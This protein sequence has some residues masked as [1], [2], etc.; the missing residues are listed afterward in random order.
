MLLG[1]SRRMSAMTEKNNQKPWGPLSVLPRDDQYS[2]EIQ[3]ETRFQASMVANRII[4]KL[5]KGDSCK[6]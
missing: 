6:N 5:M 3:H 1:F 4:A 2:I